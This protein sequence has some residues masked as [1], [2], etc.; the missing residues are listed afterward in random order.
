MLS[1]IDIAG[2]RLG[3]QIYPD[4]DHGVLIGAISAQG[5]EI[6][7]VL[8]YVYDAKAADVKIVKAIEEMASGRIDALA[9]TNLGQV[10]RK[11][12]V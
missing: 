1:R 8:P 5:A 10:D 2:H 9:L 12:V 3:L 6:D 11:S 7:T 4:K